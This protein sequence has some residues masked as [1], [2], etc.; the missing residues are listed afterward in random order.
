[1]KLKKNGIK[2]LDK[3]TMINSSVLLRL[4]V[5]VIHYTE[6]KNTWDEPLRASLCNF[7]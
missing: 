2:L 7:I 5:L 3:G 1:M 4:R 6:A